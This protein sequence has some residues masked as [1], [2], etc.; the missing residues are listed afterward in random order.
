MRTPVG[1]DCPPSAYCGVLHQPLKHLGLGT[2]QDRILGEMELS[3]D[4]VYQFLW[5]YL[6]LLELGAGIC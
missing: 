2:V 4:P 6:E 5:F 3:S 1:A